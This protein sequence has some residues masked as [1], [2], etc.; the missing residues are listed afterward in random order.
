M[1]K[2]LYFFVLLFFIAFNSFSQQ[3]LEQIKLYYQSADSG[4]SQLKSVFYVLKNDPA[5]LKGPYTSFYEMGAVKSEGN[6]DKSQPIGLW[7]FY[8]E[9]GGVRMTADYR[10]N[11]MIYWKFF[12]ENGSLKT[13]GLMNDQNKEGPWLVYY[14]NGQIKA[15]GN[16]KSNLKEG[17]WVYF[18]EDGTNKGKASYVAGSGK[19][20]EYY[21]NGTLKMEGPTFNNV[22]E[23]IW[24]YYY[25]NGSIQAKGY[26]SDG[27]K[28]GNWTFYYKNG[29]VSGKGNYI[30]GKQQGEWEYFYENGVVSTKGTLSKGIRDG[31]WQMFYPSGSYRGG[32]KFANGNGYYKEFFESGNLKVEGEVKNDQ[33]NGLWK[34]YVQDGTLEGECNFVEGQGLYTGYYA[35]GTKKVEGELLN[36]EKIGV[37]KLFDENEN[38]IGFYK[39]YQ[40]VDSSNYSVI[41]PLDSIET[42]VKVDSVP[43]KQ[44][45]LNADKKYEYTHLPSFRVRKRHKS[46]I[47]N[48]NPKVNEYKNFIVGFNPLGLVDNQIPIYFEYYIQERLGTNLSYSLT[49][50]PYFV[51]HRLSGPEEV[52]LSGFSASI[53]ERLYSLNRDIGM[54][55]VGIGFQFNTNKYSSKPDVNNPGFDGKKDL[56]VKNNEFELLVSI[57]DRILRLPYR[58]GPTFDVYLASGIGY[59]DQT[60]NFENN[61]YYNSLF[62]NIK[63][64]KLYIPIH[65]GLSFGYLF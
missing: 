50:F 48:F 55:F 57:G 22:S 40:G 36:G 34:Y 3:D 8:F 29:Q 44:D 10:D 65:I 28:N 41:P 37:W 58:K 9:N 21:L 45:T 17:D 20:S 39:T 31:D 42:V 61:S 2:N 38:L 62:S 18:Y 32:G 7:K 46:K 16:Y 6:Y 60:R 35:N 12:Y 14:E 30:N 43:A 11:R 1:R 24:T 27:I 33:N 5:I 52:T 26:E 23:G 47:R 59:R 25:P 4:E 19:Y 13:E 54:L 15:K 49:R 51:N 56:F 53:G 63:S 64:T